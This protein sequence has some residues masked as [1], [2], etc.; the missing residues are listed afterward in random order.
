LVLLAGC[1]SLGGCISVSIETRVGPGGGGIRAYQME[2]DPRLGAGAQGRGGGL[3]L[4]DLGLDGID[5][6]VL[7]DSTTSKRDDGGTVYR[8]TCRADDVRKFS[9]PD[10]SVS[11]VIER[12]GLWKRYRYRES[13]KLDTGGE[14][15]SAAALMASSRF[16]HRLRLPGRL[17]RSNGDSVD[18]GWVVWSRPMF[19]ESGRLVM[20]AESRAIDPLYP[21]LAA[22][23]LAVVLVVVLLGRKR[24]AR[25]A[26]SA[27]LL[28]AALVPALPLSSSAI[29]RRPGERFDPE[30]VSQGSIR[31]YA[32]A[33]NF[34]GTPERTWLE[35]S[36]TLPM[37]NL[38]FIKAD[39][40]FK[41]SY[42]IS[43]LAFDEQGHQAAGDS[44]ERALT[45]RDYASIG[46]EQKICTDTLR[47]G[48]APGHYRLKVV[49]ADNNSERLGTIERRVAVTDFFGGRTAVGGIRFERALEGGFIPWAQKSYGRQLGPLVAYLRLYAPGPES[50]L[51]EASLEGSERQ[52]DSAVVRETLAVDGETAVRKLIAVDS[53]AG[54][55]YRFSVST[56]RVSDPEHPFYRATDM[57][58]VRGIGAGGRA[59]MES[60]LQ[61]LEYIATKKEIL[62]LEGAAPGQR[63]SV[64]EE[65]WKGRDP[66][67]G[68]VRNEAQDEFLQRVEQANRQYSMGIRPGWR[69]DRGRIY[70]KYGPPD[71]IER[72][73][74]EPE[75]PA[76]EIWY[77]FT[78][79]VKFMFMD[80]HGFGDYRLMN[81]NAER[82]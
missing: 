22:A 13:Y 81:P 53:L 52:G 41:A 31:F 67:P 65:F 43:V 2:M 50:L 59:G 12:S 37:D 17:A 60:S 1:L 20:E 47:L 29:G 25:G 18:G 15:R 10:D 78:D 30:Q 44:W 62:R 61:V 16:R 4:A 6:L 57:V 48:L 32:Q 3:G 14:D 24:P 34:R 66:T 21:F 23:L 69:T 11:L 33:A 8:T 76:Y 5:G 40:A 46:K 45:V 54:G 19:S 79:S 56:A 73:P 70:I 36:Y 9:Q 74:F 58:R 72:H 26:V 82:K 35:V 51:L 42:T 80:V 27:V 7:V 71:E 77:Y 38:Q 68:T 49:C 39:T 64:L 75:Y 28:L 63:D 55:E